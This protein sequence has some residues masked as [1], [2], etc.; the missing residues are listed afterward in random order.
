MIKA[1][2]LRLVVLF[3]ILASYN[4]IFSQVKDCKEW[5]AAVDPKIE[6]SNPV[7]VHNPKQ[8]K[9]NDNVLFGIDCLL[10]LKGR[11]HKSEESQVTDFTLGLRRASP[12]VE[13][14]ALYAVSAIYHENWQHSWA[15]VL[16]EN[17]KKNKQSTIKKAYKAYQAWFEKVKE[18]GLEEVRRQKLDPLDG[19]GVRWY[20]SS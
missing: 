15:I 13:V 5:Q 14:L 7:S 17:G 12:S 20:W 4:M 3:I 2:F 11:K 10:Q 16:T 8:M 1:S 6:S 18:L 9:S 19:T